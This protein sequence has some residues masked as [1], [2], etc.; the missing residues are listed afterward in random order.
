MIIAC[1]VLGTEKVVNV[2][3]FV[4]GERKIEGFMLS[5]KIN[6]RQH[7]KK[8]SKNKVVHISY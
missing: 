3:K 1:N 2:Y 5:R 6:P 8:I 4:Y 7:A